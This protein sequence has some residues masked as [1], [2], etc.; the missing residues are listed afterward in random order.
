[1]RAGINPVSG[2]MLHGEFDRPGQL[3]GVRGGLTARHSMCFQVSQFAHPVILEYVRRLDNH[4]DSVHRGEAQ[5][6]ATDL[7]IPRA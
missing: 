6:E 1:M 3:L 4:L 5:Q 2:R 7:T